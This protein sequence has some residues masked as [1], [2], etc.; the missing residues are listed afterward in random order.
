MKKII[1]SF[2]F[3]FAI[4]GIIGIILNLVGFDDISLF[5]GLNPILNALSS[6]K[7]CCDIINSIPYLWYILSMITMIGYGLVIDALKKPNKKKIIVWLYIKVDITK[8]SN[9]NL[10]APLLADVWSRCGLITRLLLLYKI[11]FMYGGGENEK[12]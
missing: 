11:A 7:A 9:H 8:K 12:A 10:S 1:K 4:V 6:S 5:I 3:W 2:T